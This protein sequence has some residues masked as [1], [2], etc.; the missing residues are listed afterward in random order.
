[1]QVYLLDGQL[2]VV[3]GGQVGEI[4]IGGVGVGV[5]YV[6]REEETRERFIA[7]SV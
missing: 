7:E 2:E 4:Y 6:N 1:M 3:G 5:G